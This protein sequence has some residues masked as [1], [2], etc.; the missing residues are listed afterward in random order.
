MKILYAIMVFIIAFGLSALIVI[1]DDI[2]RNRK[3]LL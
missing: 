1:A 3:D 2:Y